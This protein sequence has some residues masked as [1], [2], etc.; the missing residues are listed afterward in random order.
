[1]NIVSKISKFKGFLSLVSLFV[2]GVNPALAQVVTSSLSLP[3]VATTTIVASSSQEEP[4]TPTLPPRALKPSP[5]IRVGLYKI[6]DAVTFT[7]EF[8]YEV[9][10]GE[11][12][13][14]RLPKSEEA[15]LA[16]T[17]GRYNFK[18]E[19]L[20]FGSEGYIRLVPEDAE[21]FFTI[22][23]YYRPVAG[24]KKINF[25]AYRG[26]L[27]FRYSPK[28]RA[29]Y[30]INELPLDAY[31]AGI[32]ESANDAPAEYLKALLIAA[33][34][35]AYS[36]ISKLPPTEKR[37]FDVYATTVDQLYL[38][39]NSEGYMPQVA[40]AAAATAGEMVTYQGNPVVTPYF[41]H[42]NG[43]TKNWK[44]TPG[45]AD[46]PWLQSVPAV[47]DK[48]KKMSGHGIG[49]SNRDA[50]QHA[51]K[52]GWTYEEILKYYYTGVEVEKIY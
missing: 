24:R 38:G 49:M 31:V 39:Y 29:S 11:K 30:I 32:A 44:N 28:S 23:S 40:L 35:Y 22:T 37:M 8:P 33:R 25:N 19:N 27:E 15:T 10:S 42:S 51:K 12:Y 41:S 18:S 3:V 2:V 9:Y 5:T 52:D 1:M 48:G 45:G 4:A 34:S 36:H 17:N 7:S 43:Q 46:R 21:N 50:M 20:F 47:Y 6:K 13:Q 26:A 16:Y 14:G